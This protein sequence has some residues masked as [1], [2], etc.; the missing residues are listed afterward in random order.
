VLLPRLLTGST[1]DD[2][3][4]FERLRDALELE[5]LVVDDATAEA[6]PGL[7]LILPGGLLPQLRRDALSA[8][9]RA[10]ADI[11]VIPPFAHDDLTSLLPL[12][13]VVRLEPASFCSSE[14]VDNDLREAIGQNAVTIFFQKA[15]RTDRG[16]PLVQSMSGQRILVA[17]QPS[18]SSGRMLITT[19]L[20][21]S[22]SARSRL[23]DKRI[24]WSGL[25][26]WLEATAPP[27]AEPVVAARSGT[28]ELDSE[29]PAVLIGICLAER[30]GA[31]TLDQLKAAVAQTEARL[32]SL[33][34]DADL[35]RTLCRLEAI[36]VLLPSGE[37][38]WNLDS[39]RLAE[40]VRR[41]HLTSYVRRL[42]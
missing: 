6:R 2:Q 22:L 37:G 32:S 29:L 23:A 28:P 39:R 35:T 21:A 5:S 11:F 13:D 14:V 17:I 10:Q 41:N 36:G 26:R 31:V 18:S 16:R 1:P 7:L 25:V 40:E 34:Q 19:F 20:L 15:I 8:I 38:T 24:F 27:V 33:S 30:D 42:R 4:R 12:G 9:L 3:T